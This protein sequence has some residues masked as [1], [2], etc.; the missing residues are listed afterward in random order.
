MLRRLP[1][2]SLRLLPATRSVSLR[3]MS[4][5]APAAV[6]RAEPSVAPAFYASLPH[7][8]GKTF[9]SPW[10]SAGG[11]GFLK[12]FKARLLEWNE[13]PLPTHGLDE[14]VQAVQAAQLPPGKVAVTWLG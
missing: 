11:H 9:R 13:V 6:S 4:S 5:S 3:A 8:A 10:P 12:F 7:H 2:H 14:L 1:V